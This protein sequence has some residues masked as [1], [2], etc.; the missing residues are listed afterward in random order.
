MGQFTLYEIV[1][2]IGNVFKQQSI[3]DNG[4][5]IENLAEIVCQA[6]NERLEKV[7]MLKRAERLP[8]SVLTIPRGKDFEMILESIVDTYYGSTCQTES[9]DS[10]TQG[11][12]LPPRNEF[13]AFYEIINIIKKSQ[14]F[15]EVIDTYPSDTTLAALNNVPP[16]LPTRLLTYPPRD[17][18]EQLTFEQLAKKLMKDRPEIEI[19]YAPAKTLHDRYVLS[20]RESFLLGHSISD[21]GNKLSSIVK[22][23]ESMAATARNEFLKLWSQARPI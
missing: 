21:I 23:P 8:R 10:G 2:H 14:G 5:F 22:L 20:D 7:K 13:M 9:A 18:R 15:L 3:T 4:S 17:S 6:L 19:R 12:I 16:T 1:H 11:L